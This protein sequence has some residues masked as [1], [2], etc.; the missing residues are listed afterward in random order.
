MLRVKRTDQTLTDEFQ[1]HTI[2]LELNT[3]TYFELNPSATRVWQQ[4]PTFDQ[5]SIALEEVTNKVSESYP[6]QSWDTI[7]QH[8]EELI[9]ALK[10]A[11][12]VT[13]E[14]A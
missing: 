10:E 7:H 9:A 4:I 8:V 12:L 13:I 3:S 2:V 1:E 5:G 11:Q 14:S 6:D